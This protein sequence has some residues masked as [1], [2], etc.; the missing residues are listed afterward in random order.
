[1]EIFNFT[2]YINPP[3]KNEKKYKT[4]KHRYTRKI[5]NPKNVNYFAPWE[6]IEDQMYLKKYGI[7]KISF[8]YLNPIDRAKKQKDLYN[9]PVIVYLWNG[10]KKMDINNFVNELLDR[11]EGVA[12]KNDRENVL[13]VSKKLNNEEKEFFKIVVDTIDS[14]EAYAIESIIDK[15]FSK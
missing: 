10:F 14:D 2:C 8:D 6:E 1:L 9:K 3:T 13:F 12:Y 7:N 15:R 5:I 11:L 4:K